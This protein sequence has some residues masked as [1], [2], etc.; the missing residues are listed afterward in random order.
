[1]PQSIESAFKHEHVSDVLQF[2]SE[3]TFILGDLRPVITIR[4]YRP[5]TGER[6]VAF[7]QSHYISTPAQAGPYMT[8]RPWNDTEEAAINQVVHAMN[9]YYD[10]A[11]R[12]GHAPDES[13][14]T[15]SPDFTPKA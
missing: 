6:V 11:I 13:W 14:L 5:I 12:A 8:S 4:L 10:Q 2:I 3:Y 15:P 1:M 9:D 7:R